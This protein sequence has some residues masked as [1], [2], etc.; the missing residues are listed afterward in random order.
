MGGKEVFAT[1]TAFM[2]GL[3]LQCEFQKPYISQV[4]ERMVI[5]ICKGIIAYF[6][7]K[8]REAYSAMKS[9]FEQKLTLELLGDRS[10][11]HNGIGGSFVQREVLDELWSQ[12]LVENGCYDELDRYLSERHDYAYKASTDRLSDPSMSFCSQIQLERA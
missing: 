1:I 10:F 9:V 12:I 8:F 2:E 3:E 11:R 6:Q 5:P 4:Y 7:G